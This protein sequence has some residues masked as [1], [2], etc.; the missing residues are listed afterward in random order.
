MTDPEFAVWRERLAQEA[1]TARWAMEREG[2]YPSRQRKATRLRKPGYL[3][4]PVVREVLR[5]DEE[6]AANCKPK[7]IALM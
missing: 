2:A 7:E 4:S 3:R 5:A 6:G 1:C